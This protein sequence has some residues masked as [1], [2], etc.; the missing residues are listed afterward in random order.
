MR[1]ARHHVAVEVAQATARDGDLARSAAAQ[2]QRDVEIVGHDAQAGMV[3]E[4]QRAMLGRRA[5]AEEQRGA[6]RHFPRHQLGDAALGVDVEDLAGGIGEVLALGRQFDAA[7]APPQ[8]AAVAEVV[9]VAAD[10]LRRHAELQGKRLYRLETFAPDAFD[11]GA[12]AIF[13]LHSRF[14]K[15]SRKSRGWSRK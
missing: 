12:G 2:R 13:R 7:M 1:L 4:R 3:G 14:L 6:I 11:D 10:R 15:G 5:D 8:Q 9:D